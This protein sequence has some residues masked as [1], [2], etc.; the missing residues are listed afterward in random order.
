MNYDCS[1]FLDMRNLK[2]QDKK[3]SV[4]KIILNFH[5]L[6]KLWSQ[7]FWKFSAFSLDFF[8]QSLEHFFLN[9]FGN[10]IPFQWKNMKNGQ[11][12]SGQNNMWIQTWKNGCTLHSYYSATLEMDILIQHT[13]SP[14]RGGKLLLFPTS[15]FFL[16]RKHLQKK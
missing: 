1:N 5:C 4:P 8:S 6:N 10:K 15:F 13:R 2:E 12:I 3:H 16:S 9:N 14:R 7:K 11:T